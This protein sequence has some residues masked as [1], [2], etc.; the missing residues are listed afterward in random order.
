M[1]HNLLASEALE[2][3]AA[4]FRKAAQTKRVDWRMQQ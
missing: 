3:R 4:N 2:I 1:N